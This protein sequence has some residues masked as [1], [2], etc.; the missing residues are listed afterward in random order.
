LANET[1]SFDLLFDAPKGVKADHLLIGTFV[2]DPG[3][4]PIRLKL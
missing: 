4:D 2:I 3:S 1:R